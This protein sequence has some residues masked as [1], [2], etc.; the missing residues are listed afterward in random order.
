[1]ASS[2]SAS[3]PARGAPRSLT[4]LLP[5]LRPYR[6]RI[7]VAG[8][9]LLL[10]ALATLAFPWALRTLIDTGLGAGSAGAGNAD[11]AGAATLA[12]RQHFGLLLAIAVAL[13]I[14]SAARFSVATGLSWQA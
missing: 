9:F 12:L 11:N 14:F 5:F 4:G 8:L 10:A 7:A 6:W 2:P 13:G 1:M 3:T